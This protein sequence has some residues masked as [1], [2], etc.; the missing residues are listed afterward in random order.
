[1]DRKSLML[2]SYCP[3]TTNFSSQGTVEK[4]YFK[5]SSIFFINPGFTT[6]SGKVPNSRLVYLSTGLIFQVDQ[7]LKGGGYEWF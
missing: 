6:N 1:M 7:G 5:G 4:K 2:G 3:T